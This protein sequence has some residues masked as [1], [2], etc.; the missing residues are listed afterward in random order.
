MS[1]ILPTVTVANKQGH[2]LVINASAFDPKEHTIWGAE[3]EPGQVAEEVAASARVELGQA[4][5]IGDLAVV[6]EKF[7]LGN[8]PANVKNVETA[9]AKLLARVEEMA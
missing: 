4:Q 5:E 3:N 8:I 6:A 7:K 1:K 9:R 2:K